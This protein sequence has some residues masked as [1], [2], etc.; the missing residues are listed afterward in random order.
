MEINHFMDEFHGGFPVMVG[1]CK[2]LH[3]TF[4]PSLRLHFMAQKCVFLPPVDRRLQV[5]SESW[6]N[7]FLSICVMLTSLLLRNVSFL[8][9]TS[10]HLWRFGS[11]TNFSSVPALP[12]FYLLLAPWNVFKMPLEGLFPR[13]LLSHRD[14]CMQIRS[15]RQ[16][17][18]TVTQ[19]SHAL[20]EYAIH[21][22]RVLSLPTV[23]LRSTPCLPAQLL[24]LYL[25]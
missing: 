16:L 22:D 15:W 24:V 20:Y 18:D 1:D 5:S 19:M 10:L 9:I 14:N 11:E 13:T 17:H 12:T 8:E 6:S 7:G 25:C 23:P 3:R 4:S 21:F 2:H